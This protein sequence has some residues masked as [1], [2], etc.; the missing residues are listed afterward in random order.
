MEPIVLTYSDSNV[1]TAA[2]VIAMQEFMEQVTEATDGKITF[3]TYYAAALHPVTEA[4]SAIQTGLTDIT[5]VSPTNVPDLMPTGVWE[6][7]ISQN[8]INPEFPMSLIEGTPV[9]FAAYQ[10]GALADELAT[11]DAETLVTWGTAQNS[12]MCKPEVTTAEQAAGKT[13]RTPGPPYLEE[14]EQLS[15]TNVTLPVTDVFEGLQ[16]GVIDCFMNVI[17]P[18]ITLGVWDEAKYF[19]PAHF[20]TSSGSQLVIKKSVLESLPLE[21][22]QILF[23]ARVDLLAK[24]VEASLERNV[25]WANEAPGKG[26]VFADPTSFNEAIDVAREA[27]T[28]E[29]LA[30]APAGIADPEAFAAELDGLAEEWA[31][32]GGGLEIESGSPTTQEGWIDLYLSVEDIDWE[33]YADALHEYLADFRP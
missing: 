30:N 5:F 2:H 7:T 6:T 13:I 16:R 21:A 3:E 11:Y 24:I 10:G 12:V 8:A 22:Q 20:A 19:I 1:E 31:T 33:A 9:Q 15:M 29:A 32:V 26:V 25:Q 23:D 17:S 28:E 4:L 27:Y 18:F 14:V